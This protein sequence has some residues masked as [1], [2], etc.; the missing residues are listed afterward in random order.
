MTDRPVPFST[1][2]APRASGAATDDRRAAMFH[3]RLEDPADAIGKLVNESIE[4]ACTAAEKYPQPNYV[5]SKLA[6][7]SGEAVKAAIHCAE[8]RE[9]P[10]E[11]RA[12][13]VQTI[14]MCIRLFIEG[15]QLHGCPSIAEETE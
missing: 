7:E 10:S 5:I 15:D 13:L 4:A 8:G 11:V 1:A 6:E 9:D 2:F 12:E 14:A 3:S